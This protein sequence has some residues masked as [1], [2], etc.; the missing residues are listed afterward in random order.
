[1]TEEKYEDPVTKELAYEEP[2]VPSKDS[3]SH[4]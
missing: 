1:M 3:G 4:C 2:G